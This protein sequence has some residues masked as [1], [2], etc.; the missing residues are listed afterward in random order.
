MSSYLLEPSFLNQHYDYYCKGVT[1]RDVRRWGENPARGGVRAGAGNKTTQGVQSDATGT[2][3]QL[4][5]GMGQQ[6]NRIRR[7]GDRNPREQQVCRTTGIQNMGTETP[8]NNSEVNR[9]AGWGPK[10]LGKQQ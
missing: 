8:E 3:G 10:L 9:T 2:A 1:R 4:E 7:Y 5:Q 6:V